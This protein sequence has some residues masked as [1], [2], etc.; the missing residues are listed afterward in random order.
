M[1][2]DPLPSWNEGEARARLV[3]Y[4]KR[5]T[6]DKAPHLVPPGDSDLKVGRLD[7]ALKIARARDR[8]VV[9]MAANWNI[10]FPFQRDAAGS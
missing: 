4:W 3:D 9:D 1:P 2:A 5:V 8:T 6:T 10:V 7:K